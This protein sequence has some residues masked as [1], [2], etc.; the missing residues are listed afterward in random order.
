MH[1]K[2]PLKDFASARC[3]PRPNRPELAE[4]AFHS[5][6]PDGFSM[7]WALDRFSSVH[8]QDGRSN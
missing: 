1:E 6:T 4:V 2:K 7:E 8:T 5:G 3:T